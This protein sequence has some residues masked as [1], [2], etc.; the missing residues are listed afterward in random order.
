MKIKFL[1]SF[2]ILICASTLISQNDI[3][4]FDEQGN[5][6]GI[7]KKNYEGTNQLRYEGAF[8]HGKEVGVFKYYCS[9]CLDRPFII[10]T[11][12]ENDNTAHV[13]YLTKKGKLVSEGD[14]EGKNRKGEWAYYHEKANS[15]MT[16][17]QY[18]DGKLHGLKITYYLNKNIAEE[19]TFKE[20]I[21]EGLNNYY[22]PEGVLLKKLFYK[23]DQLEGQA[24]SYDA[25]GN[26]V[27]EGEYK[28][29]KK[30][31]LWKYYKEGKLI[32]KDIF[33]KSSRN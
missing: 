12:S 5:R 22:S 30:D 27:I 25:D 7:W 20:G 13:K 18:V 21:K 28:K 17:E 10:K 26:V 14:M 4:Q 16:R 29:G 19:L 9:D 1:I 8:D 2:S 6:H 3:N 23:N 15:I 33:P 11:F 31:G 32:K 24:Y